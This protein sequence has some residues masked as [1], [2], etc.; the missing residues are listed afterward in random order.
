MGVVLSPGLYISMEKFFYPAGLILLMADIGTLNQFQPVW[1]CLYVNNTVPG[2]DPWPDT[3]AGWGSAA[4]F[5]SLNQF[6]G[7][8]MWTILYLEQT[9]GL[10]LEQVEVAL[11]LV[12]GGGAGSNLRVN[13]KLN[14]LYVQEVVTHF[15]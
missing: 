2:A 13:A 7:A 15:I 10:I 5:G 8:Y 4:A 9:L 11:L 12:A 14:K 3:R 1:K 6:H